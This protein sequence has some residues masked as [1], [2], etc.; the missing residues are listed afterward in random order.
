M[1]SGYQP[2]LIA[3]PRVGME[4]DIEPWLL[5]ED[6]FPDLQDCYMF[7]G[8]IRRRLSFSFLGRLNKKI[9]TTDPAGNFTFNFPVMLVNFPLPMSPGVSTFVVGATT[10]HDPEV[11]PIPNPVVLLTNGPG[12]ATL[13]RLT[14][15]LNIVGGPPLT[16][17]FY[18]PG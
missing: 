14:G 6:G 7:R 10:Y 16:D 2:F 9:G 8:R 15:V 17:V 18:F 11:N 1:T 5:P 12:V 13:N 3:N 4:R